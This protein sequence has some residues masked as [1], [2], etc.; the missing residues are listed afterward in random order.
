MR[1]LLLISVISAVAASL[2]LDTY[3]PQTPKRLFLQHM[4]RVAANGEQESLYAAASSDA[5]PVDVVL[6]GINLTPAQQDGREWLVRTLVLSTGVLHLK[7]FPAFNQE[8]K[9]KSVF[10]NCF[11]F[12]LLDKFACHARR[13]RMA[14]YIKPAMVLF[15]DSNLFPA[16]PYFPMDTQAS[17]ACC[18]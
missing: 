12:C 14:A 3:T 10:L 15:D 5:T 4:I 18:G 8:N 6:K 1:A 9:S 17:L 7:I 16:F 2:T 11:P 13:K